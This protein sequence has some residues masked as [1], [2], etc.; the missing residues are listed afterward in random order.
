[1]SSFGGITPADQIE[2]AVRGLV[3]EWAP[4]YIHELERRSG[5]PVGSLAKL[6][7]YPTANALFKPSGYKGPGFV[8]ISTGLASEPEK[9]GKSGPPGT[10]AYRAWWAFNVAVIVSAKDH[11]STNTNLKAY[12]AAVRALIVQHP[13]L[14]GIAEDTLW[15]DE[16][17]DDIDVERTRTFAVAELVFRTLIADA[18]TITGGPVDGGP[19]PGPVGDWPTVTEVDIDI[20][21]VPINP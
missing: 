4:T 8:V 12:A 17:Y 15:T 9:Y 20:N 1:M 11:A 13:S 14:G 3:V 19:D 2:D 7:A 10:F 16:S 6:H 18:Q 21:E 5:R